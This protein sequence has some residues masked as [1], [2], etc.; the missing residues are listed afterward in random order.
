MD[1]DMLV[2]LEY[3]ATRFGEVFLFAF[4]AETIHEGHQNGIRTACL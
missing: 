1:E 3:F 2:S 4:H